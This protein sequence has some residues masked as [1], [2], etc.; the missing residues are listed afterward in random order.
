[1]VPSRVRSFPGHV[2]KTN[3]N[4]VP[5]LLKSALIFGPNSSGKSNLVRALELSKKI[6]VS[7]PRNLARE[8]QVYAFS[9]RNSRET[10]FTYDLIINGKCY[11]YSFSIDMGIIS[12]ENLSLVTSGSEKELYTRKTFGEKV[13]VIFGYKFKN[14]SEEKFHK[15]ISKGT[16]PDQLFLNYI[17]SQNPSEV[18]SHFKDVYDWFNN[19]LTII[20][21]F[22]KVKKGIEIHIMKNENLREFY[23]KYLR[24]FDTGIDKLDFEE[25][26]F[27][28]PKFQVPESLKK[29]ILEK[30][31]N[32]MIMTV[33]NNQNDTYHVE[34]KD[35]EILVK[36][37]KAVHSINNSGKYINFNLSE[38]SDGTNR[39]MDLIPMIYLLRQG[40][41]VVIDEIDRSFHSLISEK[42]YELFFRETKEKG[43]Q[44]IATTHDLSL[45]NLK[46]LRRDETWFIEKDKKNRSIIYSLEEFKPRFDKNLRSAY[47]SGRFGGIPVISDSPE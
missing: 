10:E 43:A 34:S 6:I 29:T 25:F 5:A 4:V 14:K 12:E 45:L 37:L 15:T 26:E 16:R 40:N 38:E 9:G 39:I 13:E 11:A 19:K 36:K 32:E 31:G 1:M 20:F 35:G 44:L 24:I 2:Y 8:F 7:S 33:S 3:N 23:E 17:N 30:I 47:M 18:N 28:D 42:I 21:P 27:D 41:T 46:K 22:S